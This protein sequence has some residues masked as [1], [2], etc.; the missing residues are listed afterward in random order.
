MK[1]INPMCIAQKMIALVNE[2][3]GRHRKEVVSNLSVRFIDR[4]EK[5]GWRYLM[6]KPEGGQL[7]VYFEKQD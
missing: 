3:V 1:E 6:M 4:I 2:S 7:V 5:S